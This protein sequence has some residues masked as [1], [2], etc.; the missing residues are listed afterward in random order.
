MALAAERDEPIGR[1]KQP[2]PATRLSVTRERHRISHMEIGRPGQDKV[3]RLAF[4]GC[5]AQ[6]GGEKTGEFLRV[7]S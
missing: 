1:E 5:R 3:N 2:L 6:S 7:K 4:G